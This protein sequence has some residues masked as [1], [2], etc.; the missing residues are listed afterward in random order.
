MS[1]GNDTNDTGSESN[2]PSAAQVDPDDAL[3]LMKDVR[4]WCLEG[5]YTLAKHG[6]DVMELNQQQLAVVA[7][8]IRDWLSNSDVEHLHEAAKASEMLMAALSEALPTED[9]HRLLLVLMASLAKSIVESGTLSGIWQWRAWMMSASL[10]YSPYVTALAAIKNGN[11]LGV[12][13]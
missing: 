6:I 7:L 2:Q 9:T 10:S 4:E 5:Q 13:M 11:K 8:E 3:E 12:P 1:N